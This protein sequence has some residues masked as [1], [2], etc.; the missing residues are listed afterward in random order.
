MQIGNVEFED[1][2]QV[3]PGETATAI[4]TFLG[5]PELEAQVRAGREWRMQEGLKLVAHAKITEVLREP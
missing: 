2:E 1:K 5:N 4:V 3:F